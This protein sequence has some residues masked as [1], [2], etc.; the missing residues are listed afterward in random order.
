MRC[1][2]DMGRGSNV[3]LVDGIQSLPRSGCVV[4]FLYRCKVPAL[5]EEDLLPTLRGRQGWFSPKMDD[6]PKGEN[7][8]PGPNLIGPRFVDMGHDAPFYVV[9]LRSHTF[10]LTADHLYGSFMAPIHSVVG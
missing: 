2:V 6:P 9:V 7:F 8:T 1:A 10:R 5:A 4:R 3:C